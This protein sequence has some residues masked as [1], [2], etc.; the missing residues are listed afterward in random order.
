MKEVTIDV[1]KDASRRLLFEMSEQELSTLL[2]EFRILA[3]QMEALGKEEGLDQYEPMTFPFP[4][5]TSYLRK[6]EPGPTMERD[7]A[8]RNAGSVLDGQV[9][10]PRVVQ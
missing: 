5:E 8:L 6:D 9:K 4:C 1:L 3:R 2:D 10:L 7:D